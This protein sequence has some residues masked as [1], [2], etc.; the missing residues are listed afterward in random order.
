MTRFTKA[1]AFDSAGLL[2]LAAL[3]SALIGFGLQLL[4]AYFFGASN[5]TDAYFMAYSTSDLINKLLLGGGVA[6]VFLPMFVDRLTNAKK[7]EAWQLALNIIHVFSLVLL[8]LLGLVG[9]A[10][11]PFVEFIAPGF[12]AATTE[13]TVTLL[14]VL[15]PS[16]LFFFLV[17]LGLSM[18][19]ALKEFRV[20][21]LIRL[22]A[23]T[24]SIVSIV[25]L[26][27]S[28][29][30]YALAVGTVVSALVQLTLIYW[31]LRRQGFTYHSIFRPWD[32]SIRTLL[33]LVYPFIFSALVTQGAGIVYRILV[34]DLT[35][36]SLSAL[37]Y[38]EKITQLLTLIFLNSVTT[39]IYPV[40]S[41][42][43]SRKDFTAVVRTLGGAIRLT[44]FV[45]LPVTIGV[46]L[47]RA[48][49]ITLVYQHGEF[50]TEAAALTVTAL[51]FLMFSLITNTFSSILGHATMAMRHTR[52]AVAVT[53]ASQ[54]ISIIL[55]VL[56][57]PYMAHAGLALASSLVPLSSALL[58]YLYL[59]RYLH[60]LRTI[61]LHSTYL[62]IGLL[63]AA[64]TLTIMVTRNYIIQLPLAN[65]LQI[66]LQLLIPTLLGTAVYFGGAYL[67]RVPEMHDLV[68]IMRQ[69]MQRNRNAPL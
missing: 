61:F 18:L 64:L 40:L 65:G 31:D 28:I 67:N 45:T 16:F 36:G 4:V 46:V 21:A 22:V 41:E 7:E 35:S 56:L 6:A 43:A 59:N 50:S 63:A 10:T 20:P 24:V 27:R 33:F 48:P 11:R 14:R 23:P 42:Q 39:V 2:G 30:I 15:L 34:S 19:Q 1:R 25:L 44:L 69:K 66:L 68:A 49:L 8:V 13:L 32:S 60:N 17:D 12:D 26:A 9:V 54:A 62:K 53:I 38:A 55:F 29:G 47:L 52:G 3:G 57:V 37:K 58:Y 51:Q 5:E